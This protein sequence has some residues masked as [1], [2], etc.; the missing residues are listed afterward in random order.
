MKNAL[1][2]EVNKA[3]VPLASFFD[4]LPQ[5]SPVASPSIFDLLFCRTPIVGGRDQGQCAVDS[6]QDDRSNFTG[7]SGVP[8]HLAPVLEDFI[9]A[10]DNPP[11]LESIPFANERIDD[12][13][14]DGGV[15]LDVPDRL[16]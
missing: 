14:F 4:S 5:L 12:V 2:D 9:R 8:V 11:P 15:V 10:M 6:N 16:R 1:H 13:D 3:T 7:G